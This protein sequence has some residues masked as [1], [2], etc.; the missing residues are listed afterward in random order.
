MSDLDYSKSKIYVL[1]SSQE[2]RVFI[3]STTRH[4]LS[5]AMATHRT[6]YKQFIVKDPKR[7]PAKDL[8]RHSDCYIELLERFPCS[9]IEELKSR[10]RYWIDKLDCIN[11][12]QIP[13]ARIVFLD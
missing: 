4:Y 3:G 12:P 8:L 13:Y 6:R 5:S 1:K 7:V 11:K 2:S 10:E 9:C